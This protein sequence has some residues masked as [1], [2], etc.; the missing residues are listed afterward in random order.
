MLFAAAAFALTSCNSDTDVEP[1]GTNVQ[2][3]AGVWDVTI[4]AV[5]EQGNLVYEDVFEMGVVNIYTY[6]NAANSSSVMWLD[7]RKEFWAFK[8]PVNINL[9]DQTFSVTDTNYDPTSYYNDTEGCGNITVTGGKIVKNGGK[10]LHDK[11]V[12]TIEFYVSFSDDNYPEKYGYA[13]YHVH[14]TRY[15]GFYE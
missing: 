7:D 8:V 5:D 3:M 4:D 12:D 6:N 14:G 13:K 2:D 1:G 15:T 9:Q 10:N 11:P